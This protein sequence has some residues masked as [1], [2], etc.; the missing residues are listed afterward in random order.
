MVCSLWLSQ[1]AF[2]ENPEPPAW[3]GGTT[4]S[5]L[6]S[7]TSI[8]NQ[9]DAPQTCPQPNLMEGLSQFLFLDNWSL[10]HVDQKLTSTLTS[11]GQEAAVSDV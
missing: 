7:S 6:D 1:S 8:I 9:E 4:L 5:G 10:C 3:D 11:G 2:L